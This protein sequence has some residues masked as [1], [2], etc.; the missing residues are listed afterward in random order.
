MAE[1]RNQITDREVIE[2]HAVNYVWFSELRSPDQV[3]GFGNRE[4]DKEK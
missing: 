2:T 4:L 1:Y 3:G